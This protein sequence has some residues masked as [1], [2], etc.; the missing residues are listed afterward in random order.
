VTGITQE[1]YHYEKRT[2]QFVSADTNRLKTV[3]LSLSDTFASANGA[4]PLLWIS[5]RFLGALL[6]RSDDQSR[7]RFRS[8]SITL[9]DAKPSFAF[10]ISTG[11]WIADKLATTQFRVFTIAPIENTSAHSNRSEQM[12]G[13][14]SA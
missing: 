14:C 13:S 12:R 5:Q 6:E 4:E 2:S 9:A 8:P 3:D 7:S 1:D 11:S 10:L